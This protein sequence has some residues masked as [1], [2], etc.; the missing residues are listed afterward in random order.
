[1]FA[2]LREVVIDCVHCGPEAL[3]ARNF[4]EGKA[5]LFCRRQAVREPH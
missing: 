5:V 3:A 1:M 4:V 2:L